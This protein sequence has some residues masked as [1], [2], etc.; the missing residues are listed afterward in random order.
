MIKTDQ[1]SVSH[2]KDVKN[3]KHLR[4]TIYFIEQNVISE[5]S[6]TLNWQSREE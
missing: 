1:L 4:R 5:N 3:Q 6:V 2:D